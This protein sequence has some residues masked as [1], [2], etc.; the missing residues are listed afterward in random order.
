ML[1]V[2]FAVEPDVGMPLQQA[3]R[4]FR[5]LIEGVVSTTYQHAYLPTYLPTHL[6]PSPVLLGRP[7]LPSPTPL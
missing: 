2:L 3:Q 5:Q 1:I 7:S 4:Y 6:Q